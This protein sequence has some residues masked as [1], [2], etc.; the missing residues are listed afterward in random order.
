VVFGTD[1]VMT[2]SYETRERRTFW[3]HEWVAGCADL[4]VGTKVDERLTRE[5][6]LIVWWPAHEDREWPVRA[7]EVPHAEAADPWSWF[8]MHLPGGTDFRSADP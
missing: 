6:Q 7:F 1:E 2:P 3:F 4:L 5:I 8:L